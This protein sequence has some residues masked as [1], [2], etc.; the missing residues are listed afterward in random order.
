M[1]EMLKDIVAYHK[2]PLCFLN[3]LRLPAGEEL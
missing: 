2:D 3:A 1:A